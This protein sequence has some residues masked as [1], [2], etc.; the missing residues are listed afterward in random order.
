MINFT[1]LDFC[2]PIRVLPHSN[3]LLNVA[4]S[5]CFTHLL[6]HFFPPP[7]TQTSHL[8]LFNLACCTLQNSFQGPRCATTFPSSTDWRNRCAFKIWPSIWGWH[9]CKVLGKI[10]AELLHAWPLQFG[11]ALSYNPLW[12]VIRIMI[13]LNTRRLQMCFTAGQGC[14]KKQCPKQNPGTIRNF[15]HNI[16]LAL[17]NPVCLC[18]SGIMLAWC[19]PKGN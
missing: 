1:D 13:A 16:T 2:S 5:I 11:L 4:V 6:W 17:Q 7:D 18:P 19:V 10:L 15:Y 12:A 14:Q 8:L 3:V 9:E